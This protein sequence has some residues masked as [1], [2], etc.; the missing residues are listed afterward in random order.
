LDQQ[1]KVNIEL[2]AF[3]SK[4]LERLLTKTE[5]N[6]SKKLHKKLNDLKDKYD[7]LVGEEQK[8]VKV[9]KVGFNKV[10]MVDGWN[11]VVKKE[12]H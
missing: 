11:V 7:E 8:E 6:K 3:D 1:H 12:H 10:E 4:F 9:E 5:K 2:K